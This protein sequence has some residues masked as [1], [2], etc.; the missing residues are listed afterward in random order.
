MRSSYT[1]LR[2]LTLAPIRSLTLVDYGPG[3]EIGVLYGTEGTPPSAEGKYT[4]VSVETVAGWMA[5]NLPAGAYVDFLAI[6][7]EGS[8]GDVVY[9]TDLATNAHR[10]G[11]M[12]FELGGGWFIP[13]SNP[14][15][16]TLVAVLS[17]LESHGFECFAL[18]GGSLWRVTP[19]FWRD[20]VEW[21]QGPNIFCPN[22]AGPY[23]VPLS[24]M[25]T[26]AHFHKLCHTLGPEGA[27]VRAA[28]VAAPVKW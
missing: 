28:A 27:A 2:T 5:A 22:V 12:M 25:H 20:A 9:G 18:G 19:S 7:A 14:S 21:L 10:I 4:V 17:H 13:T 23:Y 24:V 11:A 8:D 6:D 15:N 3:A 26:S 16:N 1:S